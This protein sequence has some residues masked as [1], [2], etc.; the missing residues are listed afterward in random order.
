MITGVEMDSSIQVISSNSLNNLSEGT[1]TC[2]W[3]LPRKQKRIASSTSLACM[4][5]LI[6]ASFL[7]CSHPVALLRYSTSPIRFCHMGGPLIGAPRTRDTLQ[8]IIEYLGRHLRKGSND[9]AISNIGLAIECIKKFLR[10]RDDFG[11]E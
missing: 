6:T 10:R 2:H 9:G 3:R 4:A 1:K 7:A 8:S 5:N 11:V